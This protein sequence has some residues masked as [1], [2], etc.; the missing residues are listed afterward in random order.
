MLGFRYPDG[1][2]TE[3][4]RRKHRGVNKALRCTRPRLSEGESTERFEVQ[5]MRTALIRS[6]LAAAAATA[7]L[8][9]ALSTP[10]HADP[11]FTPDANDVVGVGSDTT[12]NVVTALA[13][14]Y[15]SSGQPVGG[16]RLASWDATGSANITPRAGANAIPRPSGSSSGIDAL[17]STPSLSFAR[18]SR[19]P[20]PTG[21]SG[22]TFYPYALD[23]LGYV[24]AKPTTNARKNLTAAKLK[25]IYTCQ[26]TSWSDFGG[27]NQQIKA[28]IPA[29]GSGTRSFFLSSIGET[30]AQLQAAINQPN[31]V[32]SVQEVQENDPGAVIGDVNAIAPFSFARHKKLPTA[33]KNQVG[34]ATAAPFKPTRNVYNVIR[35]SDVAA[36]GP[37][38]DNN[39]WI[40]T[41]AQANTVI[42]A[43]GFT[44]LPASQCG[45]GIVAP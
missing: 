20:N 11:G 30:E 6:G 1:N 32:C 31:N 29:A 42:T 34:L 24:F 37:I 2:R 21:D 5:H 18:S 10:A 3:T 27:A 43:Q 23:R 7:T 14:A 38:F 4:R 19:G 25:D 28:K 35:T 45:D 26:A 13:Q 12:E 17:Q 36:Y 44:R 33:T 40:C 9:T 39:G 41:S 16:Q 22:T 8:A 15:N